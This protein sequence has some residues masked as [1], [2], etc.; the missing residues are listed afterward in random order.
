MPGDKGKNT[1]DGAVLARN[2]AAS[3]EFHLLDRYEAGIVLTGT[4]VKSIRA[5][6][7]NVKDGYAKVQDGEVFLYALRNTCFVALGTTVIAFL[8]AIPA[9]WVFS[10]MRHVKWLLY[11]IVGT[12]ML[13]PLMFV[14]PLYRI[15]SSFSLLNSP[16]ALMVAD[17]TIV[18]PFFGITAGS[19]WHFA[20]GTGRRQNLFDVRSAV[21]E[22][23]HARI[24][25]LQRYGLDAQG[26]R[27]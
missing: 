18:L 22:D 11:L 19:H 23:H 14:V 12:Y 9:A 20:R 2:R 5:G 1:K 27:P 8:L 26:L 6:R 4:E 24:G 15:L 7:A 17:S 13:P 25:L 16:W 3:H 10:R 21:R